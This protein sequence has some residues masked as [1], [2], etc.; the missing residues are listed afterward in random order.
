MTKKHIPIALFFLMVFG[1][2]C[3]R[4]ILSI[5]EGCWLVYALFHMH[6]WRKKI[7]TNPLLIWS[8]CPVFLFLLGTWQQPLQISNYDFL[9]TLFAYPVAA[10][11]LFSWQKDHPRKT[12]HRIW[13]AAT[14]TGILYSLFY[15]FQNSQSLLEGL[16]K[17]QSLPTLMDDDHLRFGIFL[18]AGL[19]LLLFSNSVKPIVKSCLAVGLLG[20]LLFLSVRTA[21]VMALV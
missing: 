17:G 5:T 9:L 18:C 21:W 6:D 4:A 11:A 8:L 19:T 10:F 13:F 7:F 2:L 15:F 20:F 14:L 16:G 12:I 3:S 1:L